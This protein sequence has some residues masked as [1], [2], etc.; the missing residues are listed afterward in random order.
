M[1]RTYPCVGS[2]FTAWERKLVGVLPGNRLKVPDLLKQNDGNNADLLFQ[3]NETPQ[4]CI[5]NELRKNK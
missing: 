1:W 4:M 2:L 5:N 3:V